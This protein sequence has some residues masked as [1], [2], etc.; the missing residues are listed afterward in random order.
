[1]TYA[2]GQRVLL[3]DT[4]QMHGDFAGVVVCVIDDAQYSEEYPQTA[5]SYLQAGLLV[6]TEEAGLIYLDELD[7][8]ASLIKRASS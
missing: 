8:E 4:V 2:D 5:W 6:K 3:G 1:L 7:E